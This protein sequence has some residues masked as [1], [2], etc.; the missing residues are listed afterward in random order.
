MSFLARGNAEATGKASIEKL[1]DLR[2]SARDFE[3]CNFRVFLPKSV[4]N[5]II[6]VYSSRLKSPVFSTLAAQR[7]RGLTVGEAHFAWTS[8]PRPYRRRYIGV[9]FAFG[10]FLHF[11]ATMSTP[12]YT[13]EPPRPQRPSSLPFL[14]LFL[15]FLFG[16]W[17]IPWVAYPISYAINRGAE[18][19]KLEAAK[20]MLAEME[21][22][23]QA[24]KSVP[25]ATI[26]PWVVKKVGPSVVGI[27]THEVQQRPASFNDF[28][29]GRRSGGYEQVFGEGSGVIVD[30][31]GYILTNYHVV[32]NA[33]EIQV[34]LS[35]GRDINKVVLIGYDRET[36]LAVL[37]IEV[38]DLNAME[39][40]NSDAADVGDAVLAIG[41]PFGLSHTVT[42]GIISAKERLN[43]IP[44][45][46]AVQ[47]FLQTDAAINPGNSGGPLV[48]MQG[49]LIGINTAI[50]GET[51]Q[52]IG[53][54]IPSS[55]AEK[56]YKQIRK[57]GGNLT[58]GR[59]GVQLEDVA[60]S[61]AEQNGIK[62]GKGA[63]IV[64][65]LPNSP[66]E[67]AGLEDGDIIV[68]WGDT[69]ITGS[70]QLTHSVILTPPNTEVPITVIRNGET[71]E[72]TVTVETR[73]AQ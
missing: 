43:P 73:S 27:K 20:E 64:R 2:V 56:V 32:A 54:A 35:D 63:I 26:I 45:G 14:V 51:Y 5:D 22:A 42:Q 33:D 71:I 65:V 11:S 41:N 68:K 44:A 4:L 60:K 25:Q 10:T 49:Q 53:F 29:Q 17:A 31:E 52:G 70:T 13:P 23:E 62:S 36:D 48:N 39:W 72:K 38:S 19:A 18:K 40:G 12:E 47:E 55:L 67:K 50:Y 37:K 15:C 21:K 28:F 30:K 16:I 61:H 1:R 58:H 8:G 59:L 3:L 66:A 46:P 6:I 57:T 69:D 7:G 24:G 34:R 9:S